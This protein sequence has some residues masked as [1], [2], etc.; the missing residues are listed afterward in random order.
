MQSILFM[1]VIAEK[2]PGTLNGGLN[3]LVETSM[4]S[5]SSSEKQLRSPKKRF[6]NNFG[7]AKRSVFRFRSEAVCDER[8]VIATICGSQH[9]F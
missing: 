1:Q 7:Y 4:Q 5:D 3:S 6:I 9:V 2:D 8:G